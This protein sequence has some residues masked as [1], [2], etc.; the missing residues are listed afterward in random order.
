MALDHIVVPTISANTK[1]LLFT[2]PEGATQAYVTIQNRSASAISV[3]DSTLGAVSGADAGISIAATS[4]Q[5]QLWMNAGDSL[6]GYC[7]ST[8][9]NSVVVLYSYVQTG[10]ATQ[11][12]NLPPYKPANV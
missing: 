9:T 4:G 8:I 10:S 2:V 12:L 1:T 6:Y 11:S 5:L 3:G 7:G